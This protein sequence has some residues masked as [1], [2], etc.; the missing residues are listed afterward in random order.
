M[1][2]IKNLIQFQLKGKYTNVGHWVRLGISEESI[3]IRELNS[4]IS[5]VE[6]IE[7]SYHKLRI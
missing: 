4:K 7:Y 5:G 1:Q 6:R 3:L 2:L